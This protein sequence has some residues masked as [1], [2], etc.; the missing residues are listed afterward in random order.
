M[1]TRTVKAL[2]GATTSIIQYSVLV[3]MQVLLAPIVL[4]VAGQEVLGAYSIVMQIIGYGLLL[5][6]GLSVAVGRYL[7][8][9]FN[10][11]AK[12]SNFSEIFNIGRYFTIATNLIFSFILLMLSYSIEQFIS[13]SPETIV[14]ARKGIYLLAIWTF[15][16]APLLLYGHGL[17]ATQNMAAANI[18]GL[19]GGV[20]RAALSLYLISSDF[21]L[22]GL[23]GANIASELIVLLLQ[24]RQFNKLY[25]TIMLQWRPPD[26]K[27]LKEIFS[28]GSTYWGVNV[29]IVLTTGSDSL[30]VGHL[31]GVAAAAVF[32]TTKIPAF[33]FIQLIYKISDNSAP[34]INELIAQGMY[35][36]VRAAYIK[37][38]RYSLLVAV[39]LALGIVAFN[40]AVISAWVGPNQYAGNV[41]TIALSCFVITQVVNHINAMVILAAGKM[42]YWVLISVIAG[43]TTILLGYTLGKYFGFQWVMVSIAILDIPV[44]VFLMQ[45]SFSSIKITYVNALRE[46]VWPAL[47][48]ASPLLTL[49]FILNMLHLPYSLRNLIVTICVYLIMFAAGLYRYG[50]NAN[51]RQ[52]LFNRLLSK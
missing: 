1:T 35:E 29:A 10:S 44:F 43:C 25:P 27:L 37:I 13:G 23:V 34:A 15:I 19:I 41:M 24:K 28:F 38:L 36:N 12:N 30:I 42:R 39:P 16:R 2:K 6:L 20:I 45:R 7:S 46:A 8:Q 21:G 5:D 14:D 17:V 33:L 22:I 49:V 9:S 11:G 47:K 50:I 26:D 40:E 32:Y 18:I 3:V 52:F 51:E 31:Y 48:A 4:K